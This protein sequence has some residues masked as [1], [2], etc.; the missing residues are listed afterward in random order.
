MICLK[1]STATCN[2]SVS[3][4]GSSHSSRSQSPSG[5]VTHSSG[6]R[7]S[8]GG[9]VSSSLKQN[10]Y[11]LLEGKENGVYLKQLPKLYKLKYKYDPP[12]NIAELVCNLDFV[13]CEE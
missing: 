2:S 13:R 7:P 1:S 5:V 3:S 6:S 12:Q 8:S 9:L 11:K 10:I 4:G